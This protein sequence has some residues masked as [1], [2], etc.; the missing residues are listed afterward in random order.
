MED[1]FPR[2]KLAED[3][4]GVR[5]RS[6]A[7]AADRL[8]GTRPRADKP[9]HKAR[10]S[11]AKINRDGNRGTADVSFEPAVIGPQAF[12]RADELSFKVNCSKKA[13]FSAHSISPT[14][15]CSVY[16]QV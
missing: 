2:G 5:G 1:D 7:R 14:S 12:S 13:I 4:T 9:A 15:E 16:I 3:D 11:S 8:F 6:P 10:S